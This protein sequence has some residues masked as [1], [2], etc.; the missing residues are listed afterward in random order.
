MTDTTKILIVDDEENSRIGLGQLLQREGYEVVD[1]A[2]GSEALDH[3][4]RER[5]HLVIS[6]LNMP[7]MDGLVLLREVQRRHPQTAVIMV[8]AYGEVE[9]YL[10][11]MNLGAYEYLHKP[12]R[13]D[14]LRTIMHKLL[15]KG[16]PAPLVC[17]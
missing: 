8:T 6:D 10:E 7:G 17:H 15:A 16:D 4:H 13:L 14:E 12:V 5:F 11:A 2:S 9:S 3:L 1:V